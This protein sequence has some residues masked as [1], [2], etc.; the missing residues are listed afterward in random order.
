MSGLGELLGAPRFEKIYRARCSLRR[1]LRC[2]QTTPTMLVI[3]L[4][5]WC[6]P[7]AVGAGVGAVGVD[8]IDG[9]SFRARPHIGEKIFK[10]PPTRVN[11][12]SPA[13]V[14]RPVGS[15][16]VLASLDDAGPHPVLRC[17]RPS[18]P[19][20]ATAR[21]FTRQTPAASRMTIFQVVSGDNLSRTTPAKALPGRVT[22]LTPVIANDGESS[23][24]LPKQVSVLW[25]FLLLEFNDVILKIDSHRR[26]LP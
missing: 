1:L 25:H 9:F 8:A 10:L 14:A 15:V 3:V 22:M 2:F 7:A 17:I 18:M 13:A 12:D 24:F 4:L 21:D 20:S 6:G 26:E 23:E 19:E 16:R 5:F 11:R